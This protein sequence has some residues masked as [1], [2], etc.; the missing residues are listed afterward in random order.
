MTALRLMALALA[1]IAAFDPP[2]A[3]PRRARQT[4][5][6]VI[7]PASS[8]AL[9]SSNGTRDDRAR[10]VR[11]RLRDRLA[12]RF[13]VRDTADPAS[14]AIVLIG[15]RAP[16]LVETTDRA[17]VVAVDLSETLSPNVAVTSAS[18]AA[19]HVSN[20]V[21]IHSR[22]DARG[23]TGRTS[24]IRILAGPLSVA[25]Q[26]HRWT[27][28]REAFDA[29]FEVAVSGP[30][31]EAF[32]VEVVGDALERT[33]LDNTRA[34]AADSI[35][36]RYRVLFYDA[37]PSWSATFLRRACENDSAVDTDF[38]TRL[39][40]GVAVRA[41]DVAANDTLDAALLARYDVVIA[42]APDALTRA[43]VDAL[44]RFARQGGSLVIAPDTRVEGAA[45]GLLEG[46]AFR[47]RLLE[48]PEALVAHDGGPAPRASELLAATAMPPL[49]RVIASA[50]PPEGGAVIVRSAHGRGHVYFNGALDAWRYRNDEPGQFARFAG[51]LIREAGAHAMPPLL[52]DVSPRVQTIGGAVSVLV[53][54]RDAASSAATASAHLVAPDGSIQPVR[55][56]PGVE[57]GT[58]EGSARP[59]HAGVH[60]LKAASA[61][62]RAEARF[63]ARTARH[64]DPDRPDALRAFATS[65]GGQVYRPG[66]LERLAAD[67]RARIPAAVERR[68]VHPMRSPWW[69][70]PFAGCLCGEWWRRRQRGMR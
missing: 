50:A 39:S 54:I 52:L 36:R 40:R 21:R 53:R 24:T 70:V 28:D 20:R 17:P 49:A 16:A 44:D 22:I 57:A 60:T 45:L 8:L 14:A 6:I 38:L 7:V 10:A 46:F 4:V 67:L 19:G 26:A 64:V 15:D 30:G 33:T 32:V 47:E 48:K 61:N 5:S 56:W 35:D 13:D 51:R 31:L 55:L 42:S 66:D 65:H 11:E 41:A 23:M 69:I 62:A 34:T 63:V 68:P 2:I 9:P 3:I 27:A 1:L 29:M 12:D 59:R 25:E 37:R 58:F 18:A 43:E